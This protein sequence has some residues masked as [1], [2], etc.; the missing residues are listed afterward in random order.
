MLTEDRTVGTGGVTEEEG[1]DETEMTGRS[2]EGG[3]GMTRAEGGVRTGDVGRE[4]RGGAG[5]KGTG[6]VAEGGIK[7]EKDRK[8][9]VGMLSELISEFLYNKLIF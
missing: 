5:T 1:G 4:E 8:R 7:E 6:V 3:V 2:G 9:I